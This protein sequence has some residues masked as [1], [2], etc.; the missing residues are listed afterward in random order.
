MHSINLV[1]GGRPV[2]CVLPQSP[3]NCQLSPFPCWTRHGHIFSHHERGGTLSISDG[4]HH[5]CPF[6]L[7][8]H[9]F[10]HDDARPQNFCPLRPDEE[11]GAVLH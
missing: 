8:T 9:R 11:L 1:E 7:R 3:A 10:R 4:R 2:G 5:R 6:C